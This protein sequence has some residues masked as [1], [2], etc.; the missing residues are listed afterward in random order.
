M[1]SKSENTFL[2]SSFGPDLE[3]RTMKCNLLIFS[4]TIDC[5]FIREI[6]LLEILNIYNIRDI[7]AKNPTGEAIIFSSA[8][9]T[10][11]SERERKHSIYLS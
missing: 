8:Q 6:V 11:S 10:L 3:L 5:N 2:I 4:I 9:I 7:F 1:L